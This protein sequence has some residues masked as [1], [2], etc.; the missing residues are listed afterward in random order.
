[1][2]NKPK[3]K[4]DLLNLD[5][6]MESATQADK[7]GESVKDDSAY[8]VVTKEGALL[9]SV[10]SDDFTKELGTILE[11]SQNISPK[12][13]KAEKKT[14]V[15]AADE[16]SSLFS[17]LEAASETLVSDLDLDGLKGKTVLLKNPEGAEMPA[18]VANI[19]DKGVVLKGLNGGLVNISKDGFRKVFV[20]VKE[21]NKP[22]MESADMDKTCECGKAECKV[23]KTKKLNKEPMMEN[24]N[25]TEV[26]ADS[27]VEG[28]KKVQENPS[29]ELTEPGKL[30]FQKLPAV[31]HDAFVKDALAAKNGKDKEA[32]KNMAPKFKPAVEIKLL[33][34]ADKYRTF[35]ESFK[36]GS[37]NDKVVN[38]ILEAW[39]EYVNFV[40][41]KVELTK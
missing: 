10:D 18:I 14:A 8:N 21:S 23:C 36:D 12:Y 13:K 24:T 41:T 7:I 29:G 11:S 33:K 3:I 26:K 20:S 27:P 28:D 25:N 16:V 15:T 19:S 22:A 32:E 35:V 2:A 5:K 40:K 30:D 6:L 31:E 1:M 38:C 34:H 17:L 37:E 4:Y 9:E 39:D